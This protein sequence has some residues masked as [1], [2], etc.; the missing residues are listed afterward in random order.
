MKGHFICILV[1]AFCAGC[2]QSGS[3]DV[4]AKTE[5]IDGEVEFMEGKVVITGRLVFP[6]GTPIRNVELTGHGMKGP[7]VM[8]V[9]R[10]GKSMDPTD[11]TD[12]QGCFS[13][14]VDRSMFGCKIC[15]ERRPGS[16][17][18]MSFLTKKDGTRI[19]VDIKSGEDVDLGD[20]IADF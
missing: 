7:H 14:E 1:A 6:S 9:A 15:I 19:V 5:R 11:T 2:L 20:I 13:L 3:K 10:N 12:K 18:S 4:S 16:P 8:I 17:T